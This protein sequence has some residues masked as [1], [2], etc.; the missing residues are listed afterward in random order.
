[1]SQQYDAT[2]S[3]AAKQYGGTIGAISSQAA[4]ELADMATKLQSLAPQSR[5][6]DVGCGPGAVTLA[7][8]AQNPTTTIEA[9]DTAPKMLN[10][11]IA[12][13]SNTGIPAPKVNTR[14][15]DIHDLTSTYEPCTF[16]HIFASFVLHVAAR[17]FTTSVRDMYRIL[18]PG[19][20]FAIATFTPH[21]DPYLIWDRVCRIYDPSFSPPN[22]APDPIAWTTP[23][24]VAAGMQTIGLVGIKSVIRRAPF[25]LQ[26]VDAWAEF[27]FDGKNPASEAIIRPFFETHDVSKADVRETFKQVIRDEWDEGK[28]VQMEYVL[29]VGRK[30]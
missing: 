19:G 5:A 15:I 22:F 29:A 13:I 7:L 3:D 17:S 28:S 16:S 12:N 14:A 18:Q 25:P 6:L 8:L 1:M 23:G 24:Q 4:I 9:I 11:L 27:F 10:D 20:I 2:W 21:S 30:P 26:G